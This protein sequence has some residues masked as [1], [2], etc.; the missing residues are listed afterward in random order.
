MLTKI[1]YIKNSFFT[2]IKEIYCH[3]VS[4]NEKSWSVLTEIPKTYK[5]TVFFY[6]ADFTINEF[7]LTHIQC[8][9]KNSFFVNYK[10]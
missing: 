1:Q 7:F 3:Q 6:N 10:D 5:S 4:N 9:N 8:F 2:K